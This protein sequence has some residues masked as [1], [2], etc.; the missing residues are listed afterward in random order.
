MSRD[1]KQDLDKIEDRDQLIDYFRS[2][3]KDPSRRAFGTE[4]EKFVFRRDNGKLLSF[5]E[6]GGF[7]DLFADIAERFGYEAS[8][9]HGH[10]VALE[11]DGAA[12]TL[13]PGG[14][15]ELSGA[16]TQTVFETAAEFDQHIREIKEVAGD[17]LAF[18]SWGMNPFDTLDEIPWMPKSRYGI[19]REYMPKVGD[20]GLWMMKKTCTVQG[21]YDYTSEEDAADILRTALRVSPVVS[22]MFCNSPLAD[23]APNGMQSYRCH[24]WTRTDP[25]RTGFPDFMYDE[26]WGYSEY[27]EYVLDVPMYFIRRDGEYVAMHGKPF[28]E[29]MEEG[30]GDWVARM[31][32][33]ELHLSTIFPEVRMKKYIETRGADA[34]TREMMLALPALWKGLLYSESARAG[35]RQ[36]MVSTCPEKHRACFDQVYRLGIRAET[37]CG[38]FREMAEELVSLAGQ[39]L[40]ELAKEAG[41]DSE[42]VFLEPLE[43]VLKDAKTPA[44]RLL[45]SFEE[46]GGDKMAMVNTWEF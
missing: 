25:D 37:Q 14:Q 15:F 41:H 26:G 27:L 6:E 5:E 10:I 24:I 19:M 11:R 38:S 18:V 3:E 8:Y 39:G 20:R 4:H 23:G 43:Q 7:G 32:D 40:D 42:R 46:H 31:G 13:E 34:G 9:D 1:M 22:A 21:N 12:L 2:G 17:R 28:R 30:H 45:E 33:F 35:A 36:M 29:F 16:I 44:D